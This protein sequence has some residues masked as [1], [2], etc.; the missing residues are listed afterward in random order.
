MW[1]TCNAHATTLPGPGP[2]LRA[3]LFVSNAAASLRY[4]HFCKTSSGDAVAI[5]GARVLRALLVHVIFARRPLARNQ[6]DVNAD[7]TLSLGATSSRCR[8]LEALLVLL[9]LPCHIL[10]LADDVIEDSLR[11]NSCQGLD[12][13]L[14]VR[15][16]SGRLHRLGEQSHQVLHLV[17]GLR[18]AWLGQ[19]PLR[20]RNRLRH[21]R[22]FPGDQRVQGLL[23]L[24]RLEQVRRA[25]AVRRGALLSSFLSFFLSFF[26]FLWS[27]EDELG[28]EMEL[29]FFFLAAF[30]LAFLFFC[31]FFFLSSLSASSLLSAADFRAFLGGAA[32]SLPVRLCGRQPFDQF[33]LVLA[34]VEPRLDL[35]VLQLLVRNSLGPGLR[36]R[37]QSRPLGQLNRQDP[38]P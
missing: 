4:A 38:K 1:L 30:L 3:F 33:V 31:F 22:V 10:Q 16:I 26:A 36:P 12:D 29:D 11:R 6:L 5:N 15:Q 17:D 27:L 20:K 37:C 28:L 23:C 9:R 18:A 19:K 14:Y 24:Q 25:L 34:L 32:S 13:G 2:F 8:L 35:A 7:R 21:V